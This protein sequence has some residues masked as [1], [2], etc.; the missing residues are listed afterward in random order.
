MVTISGTSSAVSILLT[1]A[2]TKKKLQKTTNQHLT[3]WHNTL[4]QILSQNFLINVLSTTFWGTLFT[5]EHKKW[6]IPKTSQTTQLAK[7]TNS[8]ELM[9][10]SYRVTC[11]STDENITTWW[12]VSGTLS[13]PF[14][15]IHV[16]KCISL[17]YKTYWM[18]TVRAI[19]W[20]WTVQFMGS[21]QLD[22]A[23]ATMT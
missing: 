21:G 12:T 6:C 20:L 19:T 15:S 16:G 8:S 7:S 2:K 1:A 23:A 13:C 11:L 10:T 5:D 4:M 9:K 17:S 22:R 14:R 3:D 18:L